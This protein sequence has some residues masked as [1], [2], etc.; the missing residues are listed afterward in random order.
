MDTNAL[1]TAQDS[2]SKIIFLKAIRLAQVTDQN[3]YDAVQSKLYSE[4]SE[5]Q[6]AAVEAMGSAAI[7]KAKAVAALHNL[8]GSDFGSSSTRNRASLMAERLSSK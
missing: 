6:E 8:A 1:G 5:V 4:D 2:K 3:L 7:D